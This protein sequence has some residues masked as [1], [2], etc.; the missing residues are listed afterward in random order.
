MAVVII[1]LLTII[2]GCSEKQDVQPE[3]KPATN[4]QRKVVAQN[5]EEPWEIQL[6]NDTFYISERTGSIVTVKNGEQSRKAVDFEKDISS[7]PEAGLLGIAMPPNFTETKQAFAYYSYQE[8]DTYYQ[9]VIKMKET[10]DTWEEVEVLLDKIPGGRFHQGGRIAIGPDNKLYITTGDATIASNAQDLD[11][12]SGKILRMNLDGTIPSDN[13]FENSYVYTYGHR[14]PQGLAWDNAGDLYATEH[15][16][17]AYDEINLIQ[18]GNNYGWPVIRGDES[19]EGMKEPV[20]HSGES[21]WAPSGMTFLNGDF[22][23][24]SLRGEGVRKFNPDNKEVELI[25]DDVGRVRDVL[26]ADG[27]IYFITNNSD[28]RGNPAENDDRLLFISG[29]S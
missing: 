17:N 29:T 9:R 28:G 25:V 23:F 11:S 14:N 6:V 3:Q 8:N 7:Q 1:C 22:Y 2:V 20:V 12:L 10:N 21:T 18:K 16:S 13:P 24:A 26:A 27:G 5:L 15:G 19:R 4:N